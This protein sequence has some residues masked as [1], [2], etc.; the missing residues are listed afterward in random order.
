MPKSIRSIDELVGDVFKNRQ[1]VPRSKGR[2][3]PG[4]PGAEKP[5]DVIKATCGAVAEQF[6]AGGFRWAKSK[7]EFSRKVGSFTHKI[8]FQS[9]SAN[10]A[11]EYVAVMMHATVYSSAFA[12]WQTA[13]GVVGASGYIWG[14][15]VGDLSP[16]LGYLKWQLRDPA[17]RPSEIENMV[18]TVRDFVMPAFEVYTSHEA[19][20]AQLLQREEIVRFAHYA[21]EIALRL[22]DTGKAETI[23]TDYLRL[24][25][26]NAHVFWVEHA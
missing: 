2:F 25:P 4:T 24:R 11:G 3:V 15:P 7:L 10:R 12:D 21:L 17:A 14:S 6:V 22:G 26:R 16:K 5:S 9:D 1:S 18:A 20:C 23:V 8:Y 13:N 19:L